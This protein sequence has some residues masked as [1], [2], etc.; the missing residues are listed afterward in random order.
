M[1]RREL[2]ARASEH[3]DNAVRRS[4]LSRKAR[5]AALALPL[6][7]LVLIMPP[8]AQIFGIPGRIFGVPVIVAYLF[9]VWAA[10]IWAARRIS[11]LIVETETDLDRGP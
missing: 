2:S 8:I 9:L 7:G 10:L 3:A 1:S 11:R 4:I 5:D 6:I